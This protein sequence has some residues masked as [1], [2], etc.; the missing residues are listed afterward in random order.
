MSHLLYQVLHL[1]TLFLDLLFYLF[2][3]LNVLKKYLIVILKVILLAFY[4]FFLALCQVQNPQNILFHPVS[5]G[6]LFSEVLGGI[7]PIPDE[8]SVEGRET[9]IDDLFKNVVNFSLSFRPF[10]TNS[11]SQIINN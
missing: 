8:V 4:D 3:F 6:L 7:R 11:T 9:N 10:C 5:L 1:P 2:H